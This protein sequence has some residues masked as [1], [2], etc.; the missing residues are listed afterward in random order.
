[1]SRA[2]S[3]FGSPKIGRNH[4]FPAHVVVLVFQGGETKGGAMPLRRNLN[5]G[6]SYSRSQM[7]G[8]WEAGETITKAQ[9]SELKAL[10]EE[11]GEPDAFDETIGEAEATLRIAALRAKL[12]HE[13]NRRFDRFR[14]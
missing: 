4:D 3:G 12:A 5:A 10:A 2:N 11:A 9:V 8:S 7:T 1:M 13:R 14:S 6:R